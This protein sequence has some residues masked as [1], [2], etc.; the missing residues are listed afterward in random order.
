MYKYEKGEKHGN[1][2]K[3]K[4]NFDKKENIIIDSQ[5]CQ[6]LVDRT[7]IFV[8]NNERKWLRKNIQLIRNPEIFDLENMNS[9]QKKNNKIYLNDE[10]EIVILPNRPFS[11]NIQNIFMIYI[12]NKLSNKDS[13]FM[14]IFKKTNLYLGYNDQKKY[15]NNSGMKISENIIELKMKNKQRNIENCFTIE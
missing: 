6:M 4:I 12:L 5:K 8:N 9:N 14:S 15:Q 3:K 7:N 10:D 2:K 1:N 13:E 11:Y